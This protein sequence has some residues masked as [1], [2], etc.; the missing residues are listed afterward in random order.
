M[1]LH[2]EG[3]DVAFLYLCRGSEGRVGHQHHAL[4]AHR[5]VARHRHHVFRHLVHKHL[6]G[7]TAGECAAF[8]TDLNVILQ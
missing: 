8:V 6:Q 7:N 3:A 5:V 2:L 4:V 1:S